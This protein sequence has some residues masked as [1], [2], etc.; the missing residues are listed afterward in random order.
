MKKG[1]KKHEEYKKEYEAKLAYRRN[2][3]NEYPYFVYFQFGWHRMDFITEEE[4]DECVKFYKLYSYGE[5][6]WCRVGRQPIF[7]TDARDRKIE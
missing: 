4:K 1:S 2:H 6:G 7:I 3:P 5:G